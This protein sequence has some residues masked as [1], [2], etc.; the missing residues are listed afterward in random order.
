MWPSVLCIPYA[1]SSHEKS[2]VIITFSQFEE[3]SLVGN[4][5]NIE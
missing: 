4:G 1:T 5:P 2:D 3:G